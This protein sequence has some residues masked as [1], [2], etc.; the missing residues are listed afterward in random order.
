VVLGSGVP[1]A[2]VPAYWLVGA[3][4]EIAPQYGVM[5]TVPV[6]PM[7]KQMRQASFI[8][9]EKVSG[10]VC[11]VEQAALDRRLLLRFRLPRFTPHSRECDELEHCGALHLGEDGCRTRCALP[12]TRGW[13]RR[14]NGNDCTGTERTSGIVSDFQPSVRV[15][16]L[17]QWSQFVSSFCSI[18]RRNCGTT[19]NVPS[20]SSSMIAG[21]TSL[22][23]TCKRSSLPGVF[24]KPICAQYSTSSGV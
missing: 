13:R 24:T 14:T 23:S 21:G 22:R 19:W 20:S 1:L 9:P 10:A 3:Q 6:A 5:Y 8:Y 2:G 7:R 15:V 11:R 16:A 12:S 4:R 17:S 18:H